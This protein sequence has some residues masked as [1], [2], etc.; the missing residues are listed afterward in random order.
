MNYVFY[1]KK[2]KHKKLLHLPDTSSY[3]YFPHFVEE[4][5]GRKVEYL[6]QGHTSKWKVGFRFTWSE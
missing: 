4:K 3:C 6:A 5:T 1:K 2:K